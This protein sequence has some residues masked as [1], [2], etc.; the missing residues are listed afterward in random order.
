MSSYTACPDSLH[1]QLGLVSLV[2]LVI[3]A[4]YTIWDVFRL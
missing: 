1:T 4:F 2:I 3:L